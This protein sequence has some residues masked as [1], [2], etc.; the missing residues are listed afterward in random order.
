ML[1]CH[2]FLANQIKPI[3][4]RNGY[5]KRNYTFKGIGTRQVRMPQV[6]NTGFE[7]TVVPKH[8]RIDHRLK[9]DIAVLHLTGLSTRTIAI[10]SKRMLDIE[11]SKDTLQYSSLICLHIVTLYQSIL[12]KLMGRILRLPDF[13]LQ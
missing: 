13:E 11:V 10:V 4:K 9:E 8:E 2:Y 1:R 7:S 12:S 6:R 5:K 3:I